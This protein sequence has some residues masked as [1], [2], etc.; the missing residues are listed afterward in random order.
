MDLFITGFKSVNVLALALTKCSLPFSRVPF[1]FDLSY[2]GDIN[3]LSSY[4]W[5]FPS[6]SH[7]R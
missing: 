7:A 5:Q 4:I 6:I 3:P 2:V 1:D